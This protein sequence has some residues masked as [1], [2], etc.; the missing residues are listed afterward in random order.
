MDTETA[1]TDELAAGAGQVPEMTETATTPDGVDTDRRDQLGIYL[2]DHRAGAAGGLSLARRFLDE[3]QGNY[4]TSTLEAL[5]RQID[6][7]RRTLEDVTSR[8]GFEPSRLKM[9]LAVTGEWLGRLKLNGRLRGSAPVSR[10]EEFEM[11]MAGIVTKASLWRTLGLALA[12]DNRTSEFDF[13]E[14]TRR[15]EKQVLM[16][17]Q[18]RT[19]IVH[20]VFPPTHGRADGRPDQRRERSRQLRTGLTTTHSSMRWI[21][22]NPS[23]GWTAQSTRSTNSCN[24]FAAEAHGSPSEASGW[25]TLSIRS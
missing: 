5:T 10:L 15:A 14:L 13:E 1:R 17:E 6:E 11:L 18:H 19:D 7:D 12:G 9:G 23:D 22:S 25:V 2:R 21:A 8:L 16:L 4:L 24:H 20:D 3:N